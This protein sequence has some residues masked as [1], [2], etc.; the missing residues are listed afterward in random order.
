[1]VVLE[2]C[3]NGADMRVEYVLY[4]LGLAVCVVLLT[5]QVLLVRRVLGFANSF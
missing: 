4:L 2:H 1:M 5:N 3:I